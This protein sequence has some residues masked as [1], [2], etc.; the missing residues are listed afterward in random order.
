MLAA[1]RLRLRTMG[2]VVAILLNVVWIVFLGYAVVV[3]WL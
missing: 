3:W 2:L 1:I